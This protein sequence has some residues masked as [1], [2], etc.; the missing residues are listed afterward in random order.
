M[1]SLKL[2]V[3]Q[4]QVLSDEW[5]QFVNASGKIVTI[6]DRYLTMADCFKEDISGLSEDEI[7]EYNIA[8][9]IVENFDNYTPLPDKQEFDEYSI[10]EEFSDNY[11]DTHIQDCLSIAISGKGAF[12]R[13]KDTVIRFG[14]ETEWYAYRDAAFFEFARNWCK[15]YEIQY[16]EE[17]E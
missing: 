16:A 14:I 1:I 9:D 13:F 17:T 6:E 15:Q 2:L 8:R 10:M 12:R 5:S 11:P 3:E 7:A 4:I